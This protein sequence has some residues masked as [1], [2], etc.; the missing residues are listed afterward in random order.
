MS[1]ILKYLL[2]LPFRVTG[3]VLFLLL[4]FIFSI[5]I[6]MIN[7]VAFNIAII[8]LFYVSKWEFEKAREKLTNGIT[9]ILR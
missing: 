8:N 7:I 2:S 9:K 6:T 3:V 1:K 4:M 5:C